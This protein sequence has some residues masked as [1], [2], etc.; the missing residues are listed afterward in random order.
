MGSKQVI[1]MSEIMIRVLN[2]LYKK[3][4]FHKMSENH[5]TLVA[6]VQNP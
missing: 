4:T 3:M 2:M 6:A 1:I 5:N